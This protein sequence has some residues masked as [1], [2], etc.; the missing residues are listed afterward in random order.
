[1]RRIS[2]EWRECTSEN[3]Y[4]ARPSA[5]MLAGLILFRSDCLALSIGRICHMHDRVYKLCLTQLEG[6]C[7][8]PKPKLD[9]Q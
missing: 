7:V 1:M 3:L 8:R 2:T 4:E 6:Q 9:L 5:L